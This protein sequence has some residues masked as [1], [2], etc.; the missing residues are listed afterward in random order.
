MVG[1]MLHRSYFIRELTL[2]GRL[3]DGQG[4]DLIVA[5][6][7]ESVDLDWELIYRTGDWISVE[8]SPYRLLMDGPEG[9]M[10]GPAVLVRTD[11][12][13]HV[14]RGAGPLGGFDEAAFF[15][16]LPEA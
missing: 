8:P 14:F 7:S 15:E 6:R 13:T 10:F 11:G 9:E 4:G 3:V 5:R 2:S 16:P 1:T 12:L